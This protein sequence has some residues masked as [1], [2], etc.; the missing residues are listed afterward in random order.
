MADEELL[1]QLANVA[2]REQVSLAEVIRQALE[3]R[4]N[5]RADH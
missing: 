2:R 4:L 3:L 5:Q 1:E